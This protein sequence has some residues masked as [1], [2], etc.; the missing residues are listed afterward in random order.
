VRPARRSSFRR[1]RACVARSP[2]RAPMVGNRRDR[3]SVDG[4]NRLARVFRNSFRRIGEDRFAR[5][6]LRCEC[7]THS[8]SAR[9]TTLRTK[10]FGGENVPTRC[11]ARPRQRRCKCCQ[12][13]PRVLCT[14][15]PTWMKC[16]FHSGFSN[17]SAN[18]RIALAPARRC[19]RWRR[20]VASSRRA[21]MRNARTDTRFVN[22]EAVFFVLL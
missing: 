20:R 11:R 10:I 1:D 7:P 19:E 6:S 16:P 12:A 8:E 4:V 9:S 13:G 21:A 5:I 22:P 15:I 3:C 14:R 2:A 18:A 17:R